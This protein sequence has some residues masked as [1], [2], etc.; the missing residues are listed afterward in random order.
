MDSGSIPPDGSR[1]KAQVRPRGSLGLGVSGDMQTGRNL[2]LVSRRFSRPD[3]AANARARAQHERKPRERA[4]RE[5]LLDDWAGEAAHQMVDGESPCWGE[6]AH[7]DRCDGTASVGRDLLGA[8]AAV[9]GGHQTKGAADDWAGAVAVPVGGSGRPG[10]QW[11]GGR[12]PP[13]WR[14]DDAHVGLLPGGRWYGS[15]VTT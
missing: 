5:L 9:A 1:E 13:G 8:D 7:P 11:L 14:H 10:H 12:L 3:R 6:A 4:I 2:L 15:G